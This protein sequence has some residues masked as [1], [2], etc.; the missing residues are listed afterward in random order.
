VGRHP[1]RR[2]RRPRALRRGGGDGAGTTLGCGSVLV[3]RE[4]CPVDVAQELVDYFA[5]ENAQQC[6]VCINGT[7]A[8]ADALGRIAAH[9][10]DPEDRVRLQRWSATLPSRGDCALIDAACRI[11]STLFAHTDGVVESHLERACAL[12]ARGHEQAA[13]TRFEVGLPRP[14]EG[15][16]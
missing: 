10:S 1:H 16:R 8:M 6:G 7:R 15:E 9:A 3:V 12:C 4:G 5:R 13:R 14:S 2:G 11:V